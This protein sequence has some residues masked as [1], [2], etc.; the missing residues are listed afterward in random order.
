[1]ERNTNLDV[2]RRTISTPCLFPDVYLDDITLLG[3]VLLPIVDT[4]LL[5]Y[6]RHGVKEFEYILLVISGQLNMT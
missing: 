3:P 1:M 6:D 4:I 5:R 2:K